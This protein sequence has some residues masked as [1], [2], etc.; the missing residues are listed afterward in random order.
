[1]TAPAKVPMSTP[2]ARPPVGT[3][4]GS[5]MRDGV[6]PRPLASSAVSRSPDERLCLRFAMMSSPAGPSAP[7]ARTMRTRTVC[8]PI[9]RTRH[10]AAARPSDRRRLARSCT[11]RRLVAVEASGAASTDATPTVPS[12]L[13]AASAI[14]S[15]SVFCSSSVS[16][17]SVMPSS[18][19]LASTTVESAALSACTSSHGTVPAGQEP[20]LASSCQQT[21][22]DDLHGPDVR[23]QH[24]EHSWYSGGGTVPH[25]VW[26][27]PALEQHE[28][29]WHT[30]L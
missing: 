7:A 19:R 13:P 4:C 3:T 15:S 16:A 21:P 29:W 17:S 20:V 30:L 6:T 2:A 25:V 11:R 27:Q 22:L 9:A 12:P 14:V 28:P 1:M 26:H 24:S 23:P 10:C 5:P 8:A 18:S